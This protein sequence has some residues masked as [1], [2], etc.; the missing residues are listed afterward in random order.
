MHFTHFS[1]IGDLQMYA[2]AD[3]ASTF[4]IAITKS[5]ARF[6]P[7]GTKMLRVTTLF[8]EYSDS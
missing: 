3:T 7:L 5:G 8:P 6:T 2:H 1:L 4:L